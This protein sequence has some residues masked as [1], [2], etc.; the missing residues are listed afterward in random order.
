[1]KI[2]HIMLGNFYIDNMSYQENLITKFHKKLGY[3]VE[4]I[5]S[6]II[7]DG[8]GNDILYEGEPY[9]FNENGIPVNRIPFDKKKYSR[10]LRIYE[11]LEKLLDKTNPDILFI[12]NLQF[13]DIKIIAKYCKEH[14]NVRVYVDNH[15]DEANSANNWIS[16]YILHK[17]IWK[18]CAKTILPYVQK[19]YGVLPARVDF[20]Y[21]M[22]GIPKEKIEL[23][24]MGADDELISRS[25]DK[26]QIRIT[27]E[28]NGISEDNLLIVTGGKINRY[29]PETLDLMKAVIGLKNSKVKLLVFGTPSADLKE[30]FLKLCKD[31]KII[32]VGWVNSDETYK[33]MAAA[34]LVVFPGLHS[35]MWEQAVALGKPC[36]FRDIEGFH[37][38]DLGGNCEFIND[39]SV[40]GVSKVLENVL[41][42]NSK[43][44]IMENIAKEKGPQKFAYSKIAE[45]SLK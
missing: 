18:A 44:I 37:H 41:N 10:R 31:D 9:Y 8:N 7:L 32:Y 27:R 6:K 24:V 30:E 40:D 15:A 45:E 39:V 19:F 28:T 2:V 12:H 25:N 3:D 11:G 38:V 23:L 1:M 16:K 33:Y 34:D 29:R 14:K 36:I 22:Y 17:I 42:D 21:E 26:E 20:L 43:L 5:A 35:V 4:I 13:M